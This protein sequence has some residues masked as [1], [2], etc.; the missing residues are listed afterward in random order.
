MM[1]II[2]NI[3]IGFIIGLIARF[4]V[5]G[6]KNLGFVLTTTVGVLGSV[7]AGILGQALG[8]YYSNQAA[9]F[10]GSIV[11]AVILLSLLNFLRR[12]K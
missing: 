2:I 12:G 4:F 3:I 10:I 8:I 6:Y 9:G 11:G 5:S 7:L 1:N